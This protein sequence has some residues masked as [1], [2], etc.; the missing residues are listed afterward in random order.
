MK[1]KLKIFALLLAAHVVG[2]L[3]GTLLSAPL[4]GVSVDGGTYVGAVILAPFELTI[5]I[6]LVFNVYST[7]SGIL[8][9]SG[10]VISIAGLAWG[11]IKVRPAA[12]LVML[13]GSTLWSLGNIPVFCAFMSV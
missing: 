11:I 12:A 4:N 6:P 7:F 5:G 8:V 1:E 3:A 10:L 13:I 2:V 9:V